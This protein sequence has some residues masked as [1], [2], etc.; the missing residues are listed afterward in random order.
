LNCAPS[1]PFQFS[2][3]T[4][5]RD[6][7]LRLLAKLDVTVAVNAG[8]APAEEA[9]KADVDPFT[10]EEGRKLYEELISRPQA[11]GGVRESTFKRYR[12]VFDKF[13]PF[14]KSTGIETWNEVTK[15][16][17]HRYESTSKTRTTTAK[18]SGMRW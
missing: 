8:L 9:K 10:L 2:L 12:A 13:I 15:Q 7:A 18:P 16:L 3:G 1:A 4:G 11:V 5:E 17:L 14:A 6:E